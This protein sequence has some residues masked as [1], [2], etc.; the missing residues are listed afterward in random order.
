MS[1]RR[2]GESAQPDRLAL[3]P[4]RPAEL[5]EAVLASVPAGFVLFES[6]GLTVRWCNRAFQDLL[7]EPHRSRSLVGLRLVDFA[8]RAAEGGLA[9][10]LRRVARTGVDES[11]DER[12]CPGF[13]RR[14]GWWR[15][16]AHAIAAEGAPA[17]VL[18]TIA[19]I[20]DLVGARRQAEDLARHAKE[21]E[22][23]AQ[24]SA[25]R[26]ERLQA[27]TAAISS[28]LTMKDVASVVF[29]RVLEPLGAH[30]V[31]IVWMLRPGAMELVFGRGLTEE[32]FRLLDDA[33]RAG[34]R[35]PIRDAVL[36]R[37]PVWAETPQEIRERY[38]M[39]E[40]I[41]ARRGECAFAVVPLVLGERSPGVIGFTFDR[42]R[43]FS[44]TERS[45]LEAVARL[46]AQA[47]ERARL[48]EAERAERSRAAAAEAEAKRI[49][50][51]QE[52]LMAVVGHDLRTPLASIRMATDVL[53]KRGELSAAQALTLGRIAHS[54]ARM[55]G[56]LS[57]L[58]DV[59]RARR[60][61]AVSIHPTAIDL[62]DVCRRALLEFEEVGAEERILLDV[63][64][65]TTLRADPA[66]LSQVISNLVGNALQHGAGGPARIRLSGG[67]QGVAL[68][69]HNDGVP[70]LPELLPHLFE[71]FR[72]GHAL[73]PAGERRGS[74]G[75]GLFIVREIVSA[76]GGTVEATSVE[77]EG[78]TFTVRLPR[79]NGDEELHRS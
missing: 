40:G 27:I 66:R 64:G 71:P 30:A 48:F 35:M 72:R 75:L 61:L 57:D 56:I 43:R 69:V 2:V 78:T 21:A 45:F 63:D 47:F 25:D 49:A 54:A 34:A 18:L 6:A 52:Q 10:M 42:P 23:V 31:G 22:R 1:R 5:L 77:G 67:P 4:V 76:H 3:R 58:L 73:D 50:G 60:G 24:A 19:D 37:Q 28:S 38:P 33:A 7:E 70:I 65:E 62:A 17:D 8:P 15:C 44:P 39:L 51:L 41:R 36:S 53:F 16:S 55:S 12:E 20:T 79:R 29:E 32:E 11:V 26:L 74:V 9:D 59:G 68:S 14:P 13:A 46:C